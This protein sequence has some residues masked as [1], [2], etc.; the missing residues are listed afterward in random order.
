MPLKLALP[1]G[2]LAPATDELLRRAGL[3][4]RGYTDGSR[5]YRPGLDGRDDVVLRVFREKDIP[6]QIALGNYDL[7][8]CGLAWV[9]ELLIR[10]PSE[11]VVMLR[12]LPLSGSSLY[13]AAAEGGVASLESLAGV[14]RLRLVS[15]Y[16][17]LAEAFALSARL[18]AY[19]VFPV[20]GA[21]E[22]YP[23]EDADLAV[24]AA[25]SEEEVQDQGLV[26]L[27]RLL[28]GPP[29]LIGHRRSLREKDLSPVLGPLMALEGGERGAEL[30]LP[31]TLSPPLAGPPL[32]ARRSDET[33]R[34]ALPDGHQQ[35]SA[36]AILKAA[37]LSFRGY[38]ERGWVRRPA[39]SLAALEVKV[40]RP[41][42]MAQ[43]VALGNFDLGIAGRDCL[44]EHLYRFPDSPV[45]E[46]VDLGSG[47]FDLSAVVS[48]NLPASTLTEALELWRRQGIK[49]IRVASEFPAIADHYAR[50]HHFWRYLIIPI[51]GASEGF[52][53]EDADVLIEGIETGRTLAE[54]NLKAIDRFLCSTTCLIASKR[55]ASGTKAKLLSQVIER[56]RRAAGAASLPASSAEGGSAS[57]GGG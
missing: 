41:Q 10:Y 5:S 17:N 9:E 1:A 57:G 33:L 45:E 40:I 34:L 24:V 36:A 30:N 32:P 48:E 46:A 43:Q 27:H 13:V 38:D 39:S 52:V 50:Q 7:G 22:A 26:A 49:V 18:P 16:P 37:G 23:P 55:E 12:A 20:W 6:I 31:A 15:E 14:P 47:R 4:V 2:Q 35:A 8:I 44:T 53:P 42:D 3:I 28:A 19:R 51:S 25:A 29:W 11:A 21:A 56:F 54:N